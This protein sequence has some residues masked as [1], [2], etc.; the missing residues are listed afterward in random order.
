MS[1]PAITN[2]QQWN[3]E[4]GRHQPNGKFGIRK[5]LASHPHQVYWCVHNLDSEEECWRWLEEMKSFT[6]EQRN[7]T[8][9]PYA[10]AFKRFKNTRAGH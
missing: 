7:Q 8:I 4:I 9:E 10:A 3:V 1:E 2:P 6:I 5:Y